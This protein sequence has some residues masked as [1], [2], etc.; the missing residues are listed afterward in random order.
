MQVSVKLVVDP[1]APV[2]WLPLVAFDPLQ[3]PEAVQLDAFVEFHARVE[4]LPLATL[5]GLALTVTVG[6]TG[7]G[8]GLDEPSSDAEPPEPP[9]PHDSEVARRTAISVRICRASSL[10]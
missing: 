3:P 10:R 2:D 7:A 5:V 8:C 4:L 6:N 1:S 9:Q